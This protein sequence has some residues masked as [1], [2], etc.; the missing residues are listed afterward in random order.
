MAKKAVR[1]LESTDNKKA[2]KKA[3]RPVKESHA[4][5]VKP[6]KTPDD[7]PGVNAFLKTLDHPL[8]KEV[9]AV[10][11]IIMGVDQRIT[12]QVKWAAPSFSFNGYMVTFNL[13][14]KEQVHLVFHNG[15]ILDDK[16]GFLQGNYPDR[17]MAYFKDMKEVKAKQKI[18]EKLIKEWIR[19][20]S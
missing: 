2:A 3:A 20:M 9:E 11:K 14:N 16:T 17:R 10:R 18:L 7:T 12:E 13:W 8:K 15:I 19:L 5:N 4:K 6:S 1:S